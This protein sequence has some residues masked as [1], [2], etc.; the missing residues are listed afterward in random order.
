MKIEIDNIISSKFMSECH[1]CG[2]IVKR[3]KFYRLHFSHLCQ[4][5][6]GLCPKCFK[7]VRKEM[8][9]KGEEYHPEFYNELNQDSMY[10]EQDKKILTL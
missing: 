2:V 4:H 9:R 3:G 7:T 6:V 8:H 5:F 10:H 1:N